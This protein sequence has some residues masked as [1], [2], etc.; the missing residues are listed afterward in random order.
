[1]TA[2]TA[3][4][5]KKAAEKVLKIFVDLI[6]GNDKNNNSS[7]TIIGIVIGIVIIPI[8]MIGFIFE[9]FSTVSSQE[10]NQTIEKSQF[11]HMDKVLTDINNTFKQND[12]ASTVGEAQ[13]VYV[14]YL[15]DVEASDN[16]FIDK[17]MSCYLQG[18]DINTV[19]SAL[20]SVFKIEITADD[21]AILY[22]LVKST[23]IDTSGYL[24][25]YVKNSTDLVTYV[26][27]AYNSRWG[28]VYGTYGYVLNQ[29]IYE[30]KLAQ[31]PDNIIPY[32]DFILQNWMG[33]RT[34][35]CVGLIKGYGWL[36]VDTLSFSIGSNG[37]PDLSANNMY[38]AATVKGTMDTF[39]DVPG[40]AVWQDGHIGVY[41]GNGEVIEAMGTIEGVVKT[42]LS[43]GNWIGWCYIP[44]I[45][46]DV[47]Q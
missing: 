47:D 16:S 24:N 35:D 27:N 44:S 42:E 29:E 31:Y 40:V 41:I 32:S 45:S 36:D 38:A 2:G 33:C 11:I 46:Y 3:A 26:T 18:N 43:K 8:L 23:Y 19:S 12:M 15:Y 13:A 30:Q 5:V 6:S 17:L 1:M 28:Y 25:P 7:K 20:S 4:A 14:L 10:I 21:Y 34:A 9:G 22:R 39:P 37:M